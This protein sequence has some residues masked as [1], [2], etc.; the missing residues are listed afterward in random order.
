MWFELCIGNGCDMWLKRILNCLGDVSYSKWP[1]THCDVDFGQYCFV[2]LSF[3]NWVTWIMSCSFEPLLCFL[4]FGSIRLGGLELSSVWIP[5]SDGP[6]SP[7]EPWAVGW[8]KIP[9]PKMSSTELCCSSLAFRLVVCV[10]DDVMVDIIDWG[11][12]GM[13]LHMSEVIMSILVD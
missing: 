8:S 6:E 10:I 7:L 9:F 4:D 13:T 2:S 12:Y 11:D 3:V 5:L 1:M